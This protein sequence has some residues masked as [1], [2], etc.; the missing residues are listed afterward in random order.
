M[1]KF[2]SKKKEGQLLPAYPLFVKDPFF[3]IWSG[4]DRLNKADT[5]FWTGKSK[6]MFGLVSANGKVYSFMGLNDGAIDMEQTYVDLTAFDTKYG[7]TCPDFDLDVVF[8]SPLNPDDPEL[9]SCPVCY[10][11]YTVKPKTELKDV[12]VVLFMDQELCYDNTSMPVRGGRH[13]LSDGT[14][15]AWF[16]NK[17]QL[18]MSQS[19]DDSSAEWGYYYLT[20]QNAYCASEATLRKFRKGA[21]LAYEYN[22]EQRKVLVAA[23]TYETLTEAQSGMMTVAFDDTCAI[24]YFGQWLNGYYFD[25]TGKNIVEAIE[26]SIATADKVFAKCEAFD[27]KLK[28]MAKPY[29]EDYLLVLYGGLRQ[30]VGAHKLVMDRKGNLLFLSKES[31][32][33][34][35]IGTVDVSYPSIP[36]FLLFN[37]AL[38]RAMCEPIFKF[39]RMPVWTYDFAPHDVGTYPYCCG[40]VYGVRYRRSQPE[41]ACVD[42]GIAP[43][44]ATD[45][46]MP[47]TYPMWYTF[48]ANHE[49]YLFDKQMPVEE[50]GNMLIMVAAA[51][52]A[53]GKEKMAKDNWDLLSQWVEYLVKYGLMPG[54]QLCTDDFAGHLDKNINLS[55]KAIVGIEAYAIIADKL[56]FAEVGQKYHAIAKDYATQWKQMCFDGEKTPLVFDGD[57]NETF[58]LKYNM[59][60]DVLFGSG[61]FD[62]DVREKEVDRYISLN[63]R[64]G[65]PLDSRSS[66]TKSDWILWTTVLTEDVEKRKALIAPVATFLRESTTRYPFTDWYYTDTGLIKGSLNRWGRHMGFK[67]RTVQGGLFITLLADSKKCL[68]K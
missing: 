59:A 45:P 51:L 2:N 1:L 23:D 61:L 14:Q 9:L 56:G 63:N 52:L 7:F 42:G 4:A 55:V 49:L 48:P 30:A 6:K 19:Y 37:P 17:K 54:N 12:N 28:K 26:S 38:V 65:V 35:C 18:V 3:S 24:F 58:S 41:I 36:L 44:A 20:A 8:T 16:G 62:A 64:Y 60:F 31:H 67:N 50:C 53:D 29:G 27:R 5:M 39:A 11:R 47:Y 32:S 33:N 57:A 68:N 43:Q 66:Y 10:F 34:G 46:N 40:Q 25:K 22:M 15:A 21:P 13:I